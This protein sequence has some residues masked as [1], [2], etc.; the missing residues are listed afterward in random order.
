LNSEFWVAAGL[1][2]LRRRLDVDLLKFLL[3]ITQVESSSYPE[4]PGFM[5]ATLL[6]LLTLVSLPDVRLMCR[7]GVAPFITVLEFRTLPFIH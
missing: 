3:S 6:A 5:Q 7:V 2:C 1:N 4:H